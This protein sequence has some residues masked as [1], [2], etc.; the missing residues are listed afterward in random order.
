MDNQDKILK[1]LIA[2]TRENHDMLKAINTQRRF[3]NVFF[4]F[5]WIIVLGII[6]GVYQ[7]AVPYLS[8]FN[9]TVGQLNQFNQTPTKS[10]ENIILNKIKGN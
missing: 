6:Y 5:K 2:L 4:I 3:S 1:E 7:S 8:V 10:I 9:N